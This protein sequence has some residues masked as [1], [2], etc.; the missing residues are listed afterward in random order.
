MG[1]LD[2]TFEDVKQ[3]GAIELHEYIAALFSLGIYKEVEQIFSNLTLL[4]KI[5]LHY[6]NETFLKGAI[7]SYEEEPRLLNVLFEKEIEIKSL[8]LDWLDK[9]IQETENENLKNKYILGKQPVMNYLLEQ[10]LNNE[11]KNKKSS[12]HLKI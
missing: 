6:K 5:N 11:L 9:K 2:K 1:V 12:T 10:K 8:F 3:M 7:F 4:S